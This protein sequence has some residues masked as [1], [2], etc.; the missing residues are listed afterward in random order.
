MF[1]VLVFTALVAIVLG[2]AFISSLF[3]GRTTDQQR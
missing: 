1:E 2:P 3:S